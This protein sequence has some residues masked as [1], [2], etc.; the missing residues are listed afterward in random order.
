M[1]RT[2]PWTELHEDRTGRYAPY[3]IWPARPKGAFK[4]P[5]RKGTAGDALPASAPASASAS[6]TTTA[7]APTFVPPV[8]VRPGACAGGMSTPMGVGMNVHWDFE[9]E[10]P[11]FLILQRRMELDH[12]AAMSAENEISDNTDQDIA[13]A[14]RAA[15]IV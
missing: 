6:I 3:R 4:L 12:G 9:L 15:E 14:L 7:T 1:S 2:E 11:T 5:F 8:P 13:P 10:L